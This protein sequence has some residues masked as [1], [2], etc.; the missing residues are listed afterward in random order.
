VRDARG[1]DGRN[2]GNQ[3][4][5]VAGL[6]AED[7]SHCRGLVACRPPGLIRGATTIETLCFL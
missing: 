7:R 4:H 3:V 5:V 1:V 2:V 6:E